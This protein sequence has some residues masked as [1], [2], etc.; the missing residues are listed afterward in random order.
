[1][2]IVVLFLK[3]CHLYCYGHIV[4]ENIS[5]TS[6]IKVG[7]EIPSTYKVIFSLGASGFHFETNLI[8]TLSEGP[9]SR[10]LTT[11][12]RTILTLKL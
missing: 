4:Y 9:E 5:P 6:Q 7:L 1:M 3:K 12:Q 2:D 11:D 10:T 8:L